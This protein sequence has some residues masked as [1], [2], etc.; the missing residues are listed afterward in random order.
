[1]ARSYARIIDGVINDIFV[2]YVDPVTGY[3]YPFEELMP[4]SEQLAY[5]EITNYDPLPGQGWTFDGTTFSPPPSGPTEEQL[6]QQARVARDG[7]L[8]DVYDPGINMAL[9]ALRMASSPEE[10]AYAQGKVQELD[11]YA[12]ALEGVPEQAGFPQTIIWPTQPTK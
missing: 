11:A 8:R 5:T 4:P 9:R 1:M 7:L 10:E 6:A 3:E 12:V 2:C